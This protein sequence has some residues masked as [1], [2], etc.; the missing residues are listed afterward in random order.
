MPVSLGRVIDIPT[1]LT[2]QASIVM[3]FVVM[4]TIGTGEEGITH[5]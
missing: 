1:D 5:R 4:T 2:L 3:E